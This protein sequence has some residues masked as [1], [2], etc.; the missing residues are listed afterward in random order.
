MVDG[1]EIHLYT[2]IIEWHT[3]IR[4]IRGLVHLQRLISP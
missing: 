1:R 3:Y 2:I 4:V